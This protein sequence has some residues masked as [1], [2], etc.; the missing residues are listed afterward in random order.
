MDD[1]SNA[2][3]ITHSL[4]R[5]LGIQ[6]ERVEQ[7]MEVLGGAPEAVTTFVYELFLKDIYRETI[8][9]TS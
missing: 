2:S 1:S 6:G 9:L 8:K 3:M 7:L 4:A 5:I